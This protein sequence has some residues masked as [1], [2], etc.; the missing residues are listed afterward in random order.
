MGEDDG[1][2]ANQR[3]GRFSIFCR[4]GVAKLVGWQGIAETSGGLSKTTFDS[5][6]LEL[7]QLKDAK[8]I[9]FIA[10]MNF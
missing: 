7:E 9:L 5:N 3:S 4:C 1:E 8:Q 10:R 2:G 6:K